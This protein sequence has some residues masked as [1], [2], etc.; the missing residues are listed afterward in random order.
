MCKS[1]SD[2]SVGKCVGYNMWDCGGYCVGDRVLEYTVCKNSS[3][4]SMCGTL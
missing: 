4:D 1:N 2:D 3:E